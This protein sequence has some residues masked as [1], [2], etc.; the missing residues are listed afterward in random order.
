MVLG[1]VAGRWDAPPTAWWS[2]AIAAWLGAWLTQ[3]VFEN[4]ADVGAVRA[5]EGRAN[6]GRV[7]DGRAYEGRS[8]EARGCAPLTTATPSASAPARPSRSAPR[9]DRSDV[10]ASA[11]Q[12]ATTNE[13]ESSSRAMNFG[14][15]V[16]RA[17]EASDPYERDRRH[18]WTSS[19]RG[20]GLSD[21]ASE[22]APPRPSA[23]GARANSRR[24]RL[25]TLVLIALLCSWRV[26]APAAAAAHSSANP[27]IVGEW[28]PSSY[29]EY[30]VFGRVV[31]DSGLGWRVEMPS[32]VA[33]P[34]ERVELTPIDRPMREA[35]GPV[36]A[37]RTPGSL[38]TPEVWRV[39]ADEVRRIARASTW[40][41]TWGVLHSLRLGSLARCARFGPG[42]GAFAR[43]LLFGDESRI[44]FEVGELFTRTGVR[45]VLAVSGMHVALIA[46]FLLAATGGAHRVGSRKLGPWLTLAALVVYSGLSGA[47]PPVR[48][49]VMT[50][51]L[52]IAGAALTQRRSAPRWRRVDSP[53]LLGMALIVELAC[54]P[55][56]LFSIS[57][58]LSYCATVGLVVAS[59]P[60][61]RWIGDLRGALAYALAQASQAHRATRRLSALTSGFIGSAAR[62]GPTRAP[63]AVAA[64]CARAFDGAFA[65]S[66]AASLA[67]AP[68]CWLALG[69]LSPVGVV[70]TPLTAPLIAWMLVYGL[71]A[72]YLPVPAPGFSLPYE[73]LIAVLQWFDT[74]PGS[75]QPLP[76][77][78]AICIALIAAGLFAWSCRRSP[79]FADVGRRIACGAAGCA[80]LPW[81]LAPKALEVR[82]LDVGHGTAI[83]LRTRANDVWCID[84]GSN[85]RFGVGRAALAPLLANWDPGAICIA[86]THPDR[87]H[88]GGFPRLIERW[89]VRVAVSGSAPTWGAR[90]PHSCVRFEALEG[91][92]QLVSERDDLRVTVVPGCGSDANERSLALVVETAEARAVITGDAVDV[93]L[94]A[95]L[96]G[97]L[98]SGSR[99]RRR[100]NSGTLLVWPHHGEA[101]ERAHELLEA[102]D[103]R[104]VWV[105][106]ARPGGIEPELERVGRR[107]DATYR[108]G[109]L[110]LDMEAAKP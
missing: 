24:P 106:A 30:G 17:A 108:S 54:S 56:T 44:P 13:T 83:A 53:S 35:R 5:N 28:A 103:P 2:V 59:G 4:R 55:R 10:A 92:A 23:P 18:G 95:W 91:P 8:G 58:Q 97:W 31:D 100:S 80:L 11:E 109:P 94:D 75:P 60:L 38:D 62:L 43:A 25:T 73:G 49:A 19:A 82:A 66:I 68:L 76:T 40:S 110:S 74:F 15:V 7:V 6:E 86:A 69:E 102:V 41:E 79:G 14:S 52:A 67:T 87:D 37:P 3:H 48:R 22:E 65:A 34:G 21:G 45:H 70:A 9:S 105:S 1:T 39:R 42:A 88:S 26:R 36:P 71:A 81:S 27:V 47:Q 29:G 107:W 93:G 99:A 84:A 51:A 50:I 57:L 85:D 46:A 61:A 72:T 77:R 98:A 90:L 96:R 78:P 20:S 64:W 104:W 33:A 89:P 101:T 63:R 16:E 12:A 32:G